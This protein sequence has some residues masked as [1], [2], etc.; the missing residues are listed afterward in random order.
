M[1][2]HFIPKDLLLFI[3]SEWL[4]SV[5]DFSSFDRALANKEMRY[6]LFAN[7]SLPPSHK[8]AVFNQALVTIRY[9]KKM[10][11]VARWKEKRFIEIKNVLLQRF[12]TLHGKLLSK[13]ILFRNETLL[14]KITIYFSSTFASSGETLYPC[15]H[16]PHSSK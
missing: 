3:I 15:K 9:G 1:L 13:F 4:D 2:V 6:L 5:H 16:Y 12:A 11:D 7:S 14:N 8:L 10:I